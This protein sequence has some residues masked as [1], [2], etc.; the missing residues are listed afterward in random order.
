MSGRVREGAV[1]PEKRPPADPPRTASLSARRSVGTAITQ[2]PDQRRCIPASA[3]L[4]LNIHVELVDQGR[5]RQRGTHLVGGGELVG[6]MHL[7]KRPDAAVL[8]IAIAGG[9]LVAS[10]NPRTFRLFSMDCWSVGN[11]GWRV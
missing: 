8:R 1:F 4:S 9:E 5:H 10:E 11:C 7:L 3:A 6:R 2:A